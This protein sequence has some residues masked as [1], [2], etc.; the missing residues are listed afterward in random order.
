MNKK[1]FTLVEILVAVMILAI[2]V[3]MAVPIYEKTVEKSRI[4]E[5]R[6]LLKTILESKLRTMDTMDLVNYDASFNFKQMD[7]AFDCKE[8]SG[9]VGNVAY[10][11]TKNFRYILYPSATASNAVCAV[12]RK[13][14]YKG[15]VFMYYGELETDA[16]KKFLCYGS[17]EQCEVFGA[18]TSGDV[19]GVVANCKN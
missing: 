1:G 12:R 16:D 14:D 5:A 3:S 4:A 6:T 19:A 18:D 8:G 15:T 2:L 11:D 10:C 7:V 17:E 13:G 9:K